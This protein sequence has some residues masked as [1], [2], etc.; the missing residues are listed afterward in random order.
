MALAS[1]RFKFTWISLICISI[2]I[3]GS[4]PAKAQESAQ[5]ASPVSHLSGGQTEGYVEPSKVGNRAPEDFDSSHPFFDRT[6]ILLFSGI[7]ITR[8]LDYT[9]TRN[10]LARGREEELIPDD[11]VYNTPGFASLEAAGVA[12]S[13][14]VSYILH[15]TGH[16]K[17]ERW[18][19]LGHIS[20]AGFGAARNYALESKHP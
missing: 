15:R 16:H 19:S 13:I 6:N 18:M 11:V 12:A 2:V 8:A 14:G 9:S 20:V 17:L 3:A 7:A 4:G 1:P 10:M 5:T